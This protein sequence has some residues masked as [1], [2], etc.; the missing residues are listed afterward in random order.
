MIQHTKPIY[1]FS[2]WLLS[3]CC[4]YVPNSASKYRQVMDYM[5]SVKRRTPPVYPSFYTAC[6]KHLLKL[7]NF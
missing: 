5:Q 1:S 2:I 7:I 3:I 6:L 4:C